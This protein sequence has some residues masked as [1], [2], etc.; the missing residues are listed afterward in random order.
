MHS[1]CQSDQKEN[2]NEIIRL[3]IENYCDVTQYT[4]TYIAYDKTKEKH[5]EILQS[6]LK[7]ST[8]ESI[9]KKLD[10][11]YSLRYRRTIVLTCCFFTILT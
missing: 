4:L 5:D 1:L 7:S 9:K 2:L 3:L 6:I 10:L 8:M 11:K